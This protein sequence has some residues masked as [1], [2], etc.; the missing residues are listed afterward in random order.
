MFVC[1]I[2][3]GQG[4]AALLSL[5]DAVSQ[6]ARTA[7]VKPIT[8]AERL[9]EDLETQEVKEAYSEQVTASY[10]NWQ[11]SSRGTSNIVYVHTWH[12]FHRSGKL[13]NCW[14]IMR[15]AFKSEDRKDE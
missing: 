1:V 7:G 3:T 2:Q 10:I 9:Q 5:S 14:E 6:A 8:S 13:E 12:S 11:K 15:R 4:S